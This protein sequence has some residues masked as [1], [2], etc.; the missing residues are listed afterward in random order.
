MKKINSIFLCA[1]FTSFISNTSSL[2]DETYKKWLMQIINYFQRKTN[3]LYNSHIREKWGAEILNPKDALYI[4]FSE[5]KITDLVVAY[6]GDPP[7]SGV[8][9]ELGFAAAL[10][11]PIIIFT[12]DNKLI[13]YFT[14]G[15][16]GW[17]DANVIYF[18]DLND[19]FNKLD[20]FFLTECKLLFG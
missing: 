6:I 1:P 9:M 19:L 17:T 2:I 3:I 12:E 20:Q 11:K 5:I 16:D 13:P 10:N 7:S 18:N 4:D 14:R 8:L 15:L